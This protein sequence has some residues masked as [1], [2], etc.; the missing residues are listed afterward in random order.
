MQQDDFALGQRIARQCKRMDA[1]TLAA[2]ID[3]ELY[4]TE[5]YRDRFDTEDG[6]VALIA[7][8]ITAFHG[9]LH[10]GGSLDLGQGWQ[11]GKEA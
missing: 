11:I 8:A 7:A 10:D 3:Q 2:A 1:A 6:E 5:T 4:V 9:Y